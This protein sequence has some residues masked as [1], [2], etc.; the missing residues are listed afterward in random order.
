MNPASSQAPASHQTILK[1]LMTMTSR[2][3]GN[4]GVGSNGTMP[5]ATM[6]IVTQTKIAN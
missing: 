5:P 2:T 1:A 4:A 3:C 6:I